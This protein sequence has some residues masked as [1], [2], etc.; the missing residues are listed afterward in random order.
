MMTYTFK[1]INQF[2]IDQALDIQ[3]SKTNTT[4]YGTITPSDEIINFGN[5]NWNTFHCVQQQ[6]HKTTIYIGTHP[7]EEY[8]VHNEFNIYVNSRRTMLIAVG[9]SKVISAFLKKINE[10]LDDKVSLNAVQFDFDKISNRL[11]YVKQAWFSPNVAGLTAKGYM[12]LGVKNQPDVVQAIADHTAT[13]LGV[14]IDIDNIA[15]SIGFSQKGAIVLINA[16]QPLS[17]SEKINLIYT[18][19]RYVTGNN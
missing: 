16:H 11:A 5:Q 12:G 13:Y 14:S 17:H 8:D 1:K 3:K 18:T 19:Y 7:Y 9:S 6:T 4:K 15:R 10:V 2:N